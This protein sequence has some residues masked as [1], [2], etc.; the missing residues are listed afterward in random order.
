MLYNNMALCH[1]RECALLSGIKFSHG[2]NNLAEV[3]Q[4]KALPLLAFASGCGPSACNASLMQA[5]VCQSRLSIPS[6]SRQHT[7]VRKNRLACQKHDGMTVFKRSTEF[8]SH[9]N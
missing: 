5:Y 6:F 3:G 8:K 2:N 1:S 9:G 7:A 4:H